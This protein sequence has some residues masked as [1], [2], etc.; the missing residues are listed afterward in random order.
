MQS[1][2]P[3][4]SRLLGA[5]SD[6]DLDAR[7]RLIPLV[8]EELRSIARRQYQME[9]SGHTLQPTAVVNELYMRLASQKQVQWRHRPEFFSVAAK[10]VRRILVDHARRRRAAK[11]GQGEP[12]VVFDEAL[13]LPE[14]EDPMLI[15]LDEGLEAL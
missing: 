2:D 15:A 5:W 3:E 10:L 13:G 8:F 7:D 14:M 6:G 9:P 11:R 12:R 1:P 4:I